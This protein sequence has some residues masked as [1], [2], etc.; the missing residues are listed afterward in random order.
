MTKLEENAGPTRSLHLIIL[1]LLLLFRQSRA[2]FFF[3]RQNLSICTAWLA[4]TPWMCNQREFTQTSSWE[5]KNDW[6][7]GLCRLTISLGR[8]HFSYCTCVCLSG[9]SKSESVPQPSRNR[10]ETWS[11]KKNHN[12]LFRILAY[13]PWSFAIH[14]S[15]ASSSTGRGFLFF[16]PPNLFF[17]SFFARWLNGKKKNEA[18]QRDEKFHSFGALLVHVFNLQSG[19][20]LFD[21]P[22]S[23]FWKNSM[24]SFAPLSFFFLKMG[25]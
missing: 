12:F 9:M 17:F 18:K 7:Q 6:G 21:L 14:F 1:K 16:Y 24:A 4:G 10:L 8:A 2:F 11:L 20:W 5:R 19:Q 22:K 3:F 13:H 25:R 23:I 15:I